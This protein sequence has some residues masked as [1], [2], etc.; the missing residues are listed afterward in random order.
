[1]NAFPLSENA[2]SL[3]TLNDKRRKQYLEFIEREV[4]GALKL[5]DGDGY[6]QWGEE[7]MKEDV[8][9][10]RSNGDSKSN[11]I[12]RGCTYL[13]ASF[14]E[15]M[16]VLITRDTAEFRKM[17]RSCNE[18]EFLDGIVLH[19]L[20]PRSSESPNKFACMKWHA[21]KS[22]SPTIAKDRDYV[23]VEIVDE[24]E[25]GKGERVGYRLGKSVS[26]SNL[27]ALKNSLQVVREQGMM[28]TVFKKVFVHGE[29]KME[30]V[31]MH[32]GDHTGRL[33]SALPSW[34]TTKILD[35]VAMR[36]H[37]IGQY[38]DQQR[39]AL[40]PIANQKM[41]TSSRSN[42][43]IC[44][45]SFSLVK[46]KYN[47][48]PCGQVVCS[49][50]S[51]MHHLAR[52]DEFKEKIRICLLCEDK[53]KDIS[54][55][56]TPIEQV[57]KSSGKDSP[58]RFSSASTST[59]SSTRDLRFSINS[60]DASPT[61]PAS[62]NASIGKSMSSFAS[63]FPSTKAPT[64]VERVEPLRATFTETNAE[65]A[66]HSVTLLHADTLPE[67]VVTRTKQAVGPL[68]DL[69]VGQYMAP[70]RRSLTRHC[71]ELLPPKSDLLPKEPSTAVDEE[72]KSS[73]ALSGF[74]L[75]SLETLCGQMNHIM[76]ITIKAPVGQP[77]NTKEHLE[78]NDDA[79]G[80]E[81][82]TNN[83][84]RLSSYLRNSSF[85][86]PQEQND[87]STLP[88]GWQSVEDNTTG[89]TYFYHADRQETQWT[90]P[91]S[92]P[93]QSYMVL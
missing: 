55:P 24:Y 12:V 29:H 53:S 77:E 16:D 11:T 8:K 75:S 46:K 15:M 49:Q 56:C 35:V 25:N 23:Y 84:E 22:A 13:T 79:Q 82:I 93:E 43:N 61:S 14:E 9:I 83:G 57:G 39:L 71:S 26:L 20:R 36:G 52:N 47:C 18:S 63:S 67:H 27:P 10:A 88:N 42:C 87:S 59:M 3:N 91:A 89:Q 80:T 62:L 7:K 73:N 45:R 38:L 5:C 6:V 21:M 34:L 37:R 41:A 85:Q 92:D 90:Y 28:L 32:E 51:F 76:N 17:E 74:D 81:E 66:R 2:F 54:L 30:V 4:D 64:A 1:M 50:C 68:L 19:T 69:G 31:T 60:T 58:D 44:T 40:L 48:R 33:S 65:A 86:D 72:R 70:S 78:N